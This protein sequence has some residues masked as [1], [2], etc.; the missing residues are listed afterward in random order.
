MKA[1]SRIAS[2]WENEDWW[3]V[4]VGFAILIFGVAAAGFGWGIKVPKVQQWT[5]RPLDAFYGE[6]S[7]RVTDWPEEYQ[8]SSAIGASVSR[9]TADRFRYRRSVT[10]KEGQRQVS[11][12]ITWKSRYV[13]TEAERDALLGL[14][15]TADHREAVMALHERAQSPRASIGAL[16]LLLVG[17]GV[18]FAVAVWV[19]GERALIF[20]CGYTVAFL[21]AILAYFIASQTAVRAYGLPYALWA[22]ALGLLISNTIGTPSWLQAGSRTELFIKTGL[23]LLGA[24]ILFSKIVVLGTRGLLVAWIVTPCVVAFMYFFGTRTLKM[25]S[26]TLVI[27]VAAATSVCGVSAA[28]AT[29][30]AVKA[31]KDELTLAVGMTLIFTVLMMVLMP[32]AIRAIGMNEQVGGAWMGGTIDATGAVVAAGALLGENAEIVAAIVKMVQNVLIGILAFVIAVLWV[33]R[34]DRD[35]DAPRT[36]VMEIWY[37]F[38]KFI[39]G[40]VAASLVFSFVLIPAFG[41]GQTGL[42]VVEQDVIRAVTKTCRDWLFCLAFVSIGLESNFRQLA[43]QMAG[44]KPIVLYVVGQTFNLILTLIAAYIAFGGWLLD[45]ISLQ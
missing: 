32:V 42:D 45:P 16:L 5:A 44:G 28:I 22:L 2:L 25:A 35:P 19:M 8:Q 27:I 15:S 43:G 41:G 37:R 13:M 21:L 33:T 17:L 1:S 38:P 26:K 12:A 10:F 9:P 29:A 6:V 34:V 14:V 20:G 11:E 24:E 31:K 4:W 3:A 36:G 23:V 40:F 39:V 7:V 18:A 30:A